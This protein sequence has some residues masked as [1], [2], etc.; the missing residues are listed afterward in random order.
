MGPFAALLKAEWCLCIRYLCMR[1]GISLSQCTTCGSLSRVSEAPRLA[2][3]GND[4]PVNLKFNKNLT[5]R[6]TYYHHVAAYPLRPRRR[7]SAIRTRIERY[8]G[9]H[10]LRI[11]YALFWLGLCVPA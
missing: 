10:G 4:L 6:N 3:A 8:R 11:P 1:G 5:R 9:T 7:E 2:V